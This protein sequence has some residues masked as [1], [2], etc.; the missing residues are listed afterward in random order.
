MSNLIDP[1]IPRRWIPLNDREQAPAEEVVK[2][3]YWVVGKYIDQRLEGLEF[4]YEDKREGRWYWIKLE[5]GLIY[6][7]KT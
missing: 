6:L 1:I 4:K 2:E 3:Q 5:R 7:T